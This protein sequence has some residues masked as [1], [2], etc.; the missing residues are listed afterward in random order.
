MHVFSCPLVFLFPWYI[1][2]ASFSLRTDNSIKIKQ[3]RKYLFKMLGM[4]GIPGQSEV[5]NVI[6]Y[7]VKLI[8]SNFPLSYNCISFFIYNDD[9]QKLQ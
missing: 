4:L 7:K 3:F 1:N 8:W 2:G 9:K 5:N 6:E